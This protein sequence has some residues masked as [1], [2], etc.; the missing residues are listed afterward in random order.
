MPVEY[1]VDYRLSDSAE[2]VH[3]G[4]WDNDL[5]PTRTVESGAVVE[6]ECRGAPNG[7]FDRDSTAADLETMSFE[8]HPLTGPVH[9]AGA[10]PGDVL[11]IELLDFEH[12]G[13]GVTYFYPEE[14]SKGLLPAEFDEPGLHI[15]ELDDNVGQFVDGIEVPLDPF[16]GIAG[17][18]PAEDWE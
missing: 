18:A 17:F 6:F 14:E 12:K 13:F 11:E 3:L 16:P 7:A 9:V 2:N 10:Q 8:G 4:V 1:E 5:E 15:W